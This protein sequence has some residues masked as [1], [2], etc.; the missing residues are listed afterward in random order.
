MEK[1]SRI[2]NTGR[3]ERVQY[4]M[5]WSGWALM[6]KRSWVQTWREQGNE[7]HGDLGEDGSMQREALQRNSRAKGLRGTLCLWCLR[8][9]EEPSVAAGAQA[10]R[11]E[12]AWMER[13][14]DRHPSLV[15]NNS[16]KPRWW[17]RPRRGSVGRKAGH[18]GVFSP[19]NN[20]QRHFSNMEDNEQHCWSN[21]LFF[22]E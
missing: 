6:R 16:Y 19:G 5:G 10:R 11:G 4:Y 9:S 7:L 21:L 13:K 17:E 1:I 12:G 2:R 3:A 22:S 18:T 8:K 15:W 14:K 20:L